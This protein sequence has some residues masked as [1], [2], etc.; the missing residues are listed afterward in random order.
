MLTLEHLMPQKWEDHWPMPEGSEEAD[1]MNRN[2][3]LNRMGNLTILTK[4]LNSSISNGSWSSKRR[5]LHEHTVLLMNSALAGLE[6]WDEETITAR[7][8]DLGNRFCKLWPR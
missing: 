3:L 6:R 7:C 4:K 1:R 5:H 8:E 2:A